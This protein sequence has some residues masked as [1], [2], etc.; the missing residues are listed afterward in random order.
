MLKKLIRICLLIYVLL[1]VSPLFADNL[2]P[3]APFFPDKIIYLTNTHS[4]FHRRINYHIQH[5]IKSEGL[6]I[7]TG[8]PDKKSDYILEM[9]HGIGCPNLGYDEKCHILVIWNLFRGDNTPISGWKAFYPLHIPTDYHLNRF[10]NYK[11]PPHAVAQI[12]NDFIKSLNYETLKTQNTDKVYIKPDILSDQ[13]TLCTSESLYEFYKKAG[14]YTTDQAYDAR[15]YIKTLVTPIKNTQ[16]YTSLNIKR[17]IVDRLTGQNQ[18]FN[19]NSQVEKDFLAQNSYDCTQSATITIQ[20]IG[21]FID[22][23][24]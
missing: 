6:K 17:I 9:T 16:N 12:G 22:Q 1:C 7:L 10:K 21:L 13:T 18:V 24:P 14:L 3:T 11:I 15:F 19:I 5:D 2:I 23:A 8:Y 4:D 20:K